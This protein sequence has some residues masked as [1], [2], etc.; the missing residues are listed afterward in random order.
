[1]AA[2]HF[3]LCDLGERVGSHPLVGGHLQQGFGQTEGF[4]FPTCVALETD[5]RRDGVG[6]TWLAF[7][8]GAEIAD[9][10]ARHGSTW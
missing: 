10:R 1:M 9:R 7:E 8:Y 6:S 5:Q 4:F 3:E 2:R